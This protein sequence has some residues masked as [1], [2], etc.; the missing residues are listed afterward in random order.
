MTVTVS[1]RKWPYM[2]GQQRGREV[3]H[4]SSS[5]R[6][7]VLSPPVTHGQCSGTSAS[8]GHIVS[9]FNSQHF[10]KPKL[11]RRGSKT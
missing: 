3:G 9:E 7:A 11:V 10:K 2:S 6:R 8:P 1:D 4:S 5:S